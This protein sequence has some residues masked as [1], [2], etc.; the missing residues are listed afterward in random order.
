MSNIKTVKWERK[1]IL[2]DS[3]PFDVLGFLLYMECVGDDVL[4]DVDYLLS[5]GLKLE[6]LELVSDA[7]EKMGIVTKVINKSN[8]DNFIHPE[9]ET[10]N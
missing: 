5:R 9:H 4:I 3:M 7:L 8:D 6:N 1:Y 10:V 2:D